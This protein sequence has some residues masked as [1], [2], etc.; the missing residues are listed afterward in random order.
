MVMV[1][2]WVTLIILGVGLIAALIALRFRR[3]RAKR[4]T[5]RVANSA[6]VDALPAVK[7]SRRIALM[8]AA[9]SV[10]LA[11]TLVLTSALLSGRL[12]TERVEQP[13]TQSRDIVLCL[14][15]SG[16]MS[17]VDADLLMTFNEI[18]QRFDGE[19]V[20]LT[21][22]NSRA[23]TVFPLTHDYL[24]SRRQLEAGAQLIGGQS[25]TTAEGDAKATEN[26]RDAL[27]EQLRA[28]SQSTGAG[29]SLIG[30]G[31]VSCSQQFDRSDESRS[32]FIIFATDNQL[33]G[34]PLYQLP[35]AMEAAKRRGATVYTLAPDSVIGGAE[36]EELRT[37][38]ERTGGRMW[39]TGSAQSVDTIVAEIQKSQ[40]A[41]TGG[42]KRSYYTDHPA[43]FWLASLLAMVGVVAVGWRQR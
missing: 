32:R 24:M 37:E 7:R 6:Y 27:L 2:W 25:S 20:G 18:V 36:L 39:A 16:S 41:K 29:S 4:P 34:T 1:L 21:V 40:A 43:P 3:A 10:L 19:R 30:D 11:A 8:L 5:I 28:T 13:S 42:A 26:D 14:D 15:V 31:L 33:A 9:T 23:V 38:T 12:A 35:E 17:A 22:F